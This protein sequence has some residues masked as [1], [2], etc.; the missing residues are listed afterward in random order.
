MNESKSKYSPCYLIAFGFLVFICTRSALTFLMVS[1]FTNDPNSDVEIYR[2]LAQTWPAFDGD[3]MTMY[4]QYPIFSGFLMYPIAVS[5][6]LFQEHGARFYFLVMDF[7][8]TA[9]AIL[10][11][12]RNKDIKRKLFVVLVTA[13]VFAPLSSIW[14]QDE[15]FTAL[16]LVA[17]WGLL[18][19][20]ASKALSFVLIVLLTLSAKIFFLVPLV[21]LAILIFREKN[22]SL[23]SL[24]TLGGIIVGTL[25]ISLYGIVLAEYQPKNDFAISLW[26]ALPW[27]GLN[28]YDFMSRVGL[29]VF[30]IASV[31][32]SLT[33][34]NSINDVKDLFLMSAI[35]TH[36]FCL[37]THHVN[38]E[39]YIFPILCYLLL[40]S[41]SK[42]TVLFSYLILAVWFLCWAVNVSYFLTMR[43]YLGATA[44][45][46]TI[47][48]FNTLSTV[49][50]CCSVND[51][52]KGR[53]YV[54]KRLIE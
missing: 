14:I 45:V 51:F 29:L 53:P 50:I 54:F 6:E 11:V 37:T 25:G 35:I 26:S 46:S 27:L 52:A 15:L 47:I 48:L 40:Y 7:F 4:G 32:F 39:Y 30:T 31:V 10:L 16:G 8:V 38:P 5:E 36:F 22:W 21:L 9:L 2:F 20:D 33:Y 28:D 23:G 49:L 42:K 24:L 17:L 3:R 43:S 1:I 44:H 13:I 19:T 12:F 18:M 41:S 34:M